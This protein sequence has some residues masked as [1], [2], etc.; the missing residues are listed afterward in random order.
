MFSANHRQHL[1]VAFR[2][3][4]EMLSQVLARIGAAPGA[5]LFQSFQDDSDDATRERAQMAVANLREE[6]RGFMTT[7]DLNARSPEITALH[8]AH[9]MLAL[10]M[11]GAT[12]L[13]GRYLRGYGEL[14]PEES[15]QLDALSSRMRERLAALDAALRTD[16]PNGP[17]TRGIDDE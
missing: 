3:L 13:G 4:D 6:M 9:A 17:K 11:V 2:H 12:E 15:A 10:T 7:H 16:M 8:A 5:S 1:L 14:S